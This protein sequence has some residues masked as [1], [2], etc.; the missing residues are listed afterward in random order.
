[1]SYDYVFIPY[2]PYT[3]P[4]PY[5]S[6]YFTEYILYPGYLTQRLVLTPFVCLFVFF[7]FLDISVSA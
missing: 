2:I 7:F 6:L 3:P 1:M 5:L 4:I